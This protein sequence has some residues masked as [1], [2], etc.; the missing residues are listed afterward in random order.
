MQVLEIGTL[1][2]TRPLRSLEGVK[3]NPLADNQR[4]LEEGEKR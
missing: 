1:V 2:L 4:V 3:L